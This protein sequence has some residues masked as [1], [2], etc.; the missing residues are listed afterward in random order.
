MISQ[1][2]ILKR[3]GEIAKEIKSV[4][5]NSKQTVELVCVL[6]GSSVFFHYLTQAL[7]KERLCFG[8]HFM[9]VKSY[10]GSASTGTVSIQDIG[11]DF[12]ESLKGNHVIVVEDIVDT[13]VTLSKL[14][15]KIKEDFTKEF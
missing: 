13:G 12:L 9:R 10:H 2:Q 7:S 8:I 3:T 11:S 4:Y 14:L 1:D 5:K 6:K 15:P